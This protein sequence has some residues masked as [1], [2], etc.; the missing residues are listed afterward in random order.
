M[1]DGPDS[2]VALFACSSHVVEAPTSF[3]KGSCIRDATKPIVGDE[4]RSIAGK[5]VE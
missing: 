5:G 2:A 4:G 3:L 1:Q